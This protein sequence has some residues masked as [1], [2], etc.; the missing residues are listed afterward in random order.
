MKQYRDL[1]DNMVIHIVPYVDSVWSPENGDDSGSCDVSIDSN[2]DVNHLFSAGNRS[3]PRVRILIKLF[4]QFGY[5]AA[6]NLESGAMGVRLPTLNESETDS[7]EI[8]TKLTE[9]LDA[10]GGSCSR[11]IPEELPGSFLDYAYQQHSAFIA[12][13][14]VECCARPSASD[15][16]QLYQRVQ[17]TL[18]QFLTSALAMSVAGIV[19]SEQGGGIVHNVQLTVTTSSRP[20]V[21]ILSDGAFSF[22]APPGTLYI[23]GKKVGH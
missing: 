14:Y 16:Y 19:H 23:A 8:L 17:P 1:I 20:N 9:S 11:G 7:A 3:D 21:P 6:L 5:A 12:T 13:A 22:L 2:D 15:L 18:I 4:E 10:I